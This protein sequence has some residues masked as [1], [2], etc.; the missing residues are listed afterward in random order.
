MSND[1]LRDAI[2]AA[3]VRNPDAP[4]II[5]AV[6]GMSAKRVR[7]IRDG[8][9]DPPSITEKITLEALA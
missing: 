4:Q 9:G 1:Q 8:K 2:K 3:C 6:A 5:A 7:E